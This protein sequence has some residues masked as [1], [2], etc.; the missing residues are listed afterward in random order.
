VSPSPSIGQY[1]NKLKLIK[2]ELQHRPILQQLLMVFGS[3]TEGRLEVSRFHG[4]K[5]EMAASRKLHLIPHTHART[6]HQDQRGLGSRN[7]SL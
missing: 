3:P 4:F 6:C 5:P 7:D 2:L 1:F